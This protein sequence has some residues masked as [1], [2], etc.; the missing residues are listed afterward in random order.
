MSK[1]QPALARLSMPES[2]EAILGPPPLLRYEDRGAYDALMA[3]VAASLEPRDTIE[4]ICVKDV[5]ECTWEIIRYHRF[6]ATVIDSQIADQLNSLLSPPDISETET[7]TEWTVQLNSY[8]KEVTRKRSE[9]E[10]KQQRQLR[11]RIIEE[12][13]A[14]PYF[15]GE[16]RDYSRTYA[17][18]FMETIDKVN[19]IE[20]LLLFAERRRNA[21]LLRIE[22][23]RSNAA[24]ARRAGSDIVDADFKNIEAANAPRKLKKSA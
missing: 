7:R 6:K 17:Q 16:A 19:K 24:A 13:K 21:A 5:V 12:R 2:L 23:Y 22:Q 1:K 8:T 9:E 14:S 11:E 10:L 4:W 20:T 18:A 15:T 3:Q